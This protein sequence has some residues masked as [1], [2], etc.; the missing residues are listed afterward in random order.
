MLKRKCNNSEI[1]QM[2]TIVISNHDYKFEQI[3]RD[4]QFN[5]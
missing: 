1:S 3:K 4:Y 2:A 5:H